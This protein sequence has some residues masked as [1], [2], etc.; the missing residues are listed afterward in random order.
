MQDDN[1]GLFQGV[2][3][4]HITPHSFF[5]LLERKIKNCQVKIFLLLRIGILIRSTICRMRLQ[6]PKLPTLHY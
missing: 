4:N 1:R 6:I 3:D 2:Q 5:L